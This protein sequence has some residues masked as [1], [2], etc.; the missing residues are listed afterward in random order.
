MVTEQIFNIDTYN[1]YIRLCDC[2]IHR[3]LAKKVLVIAY[4]GDWYDNSSQVFSNLDCSL[5]DVLAYPEHSDVFNL[6]PNRI[7]FKNQ[8]EDE[9]IENARPALM[10]NEELYRALDSLPWEPMYVINAYH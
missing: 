9:I 1:N 3:S 4:D 5:E 8:D 7:Y 2:L 10:T 6:D